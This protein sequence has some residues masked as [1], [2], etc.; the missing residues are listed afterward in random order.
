MRNKKKSIKVKEASTVG[1][2]LAYFVA[3]K[4]RET[5][6]EGILDQKRL[7]LSVRVSGQTWSEGS[8]LRDF[9]FFIAGE[10]D[11]KPRKN[12]GT[13]SSAYI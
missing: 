5:F 10:E 8:L 6:A 12:K 9:D 13:R 11:S 7:S 3:M 1:L 2:N 4:K